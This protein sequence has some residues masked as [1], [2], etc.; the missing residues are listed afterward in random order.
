MGTLKS[1]T[2]VV[3]CIVTRGD[4]DLTPILD[5]LIFEDVVVWDNSIRPDWKCAGRYLAALEARS[6]WVY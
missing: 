4:V 5:S 3:A 1:H 2:D 6:L